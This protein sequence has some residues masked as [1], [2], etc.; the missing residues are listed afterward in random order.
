[1]KCFRHPEN[2]A[3]G[4]CKQCCKGLC[5]LCAVDLGVGLSCKG[6]CEQS[7]A[8]MVLVKPKALRITVILLCFLLVFLSFCA[9]V[10]VG[11]VSVFGRCMLVVGVVSLLLMIQQISSVLKLTKHKPSIQQ[12]RP[13]SADDRVDH[14]EEKFRKLESEETRIDK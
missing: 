11:L 8:E 2:D 1:M 13:G 5:S 6:A 10:D 4:S 9:V 14:L 3:L 7:V 12:A